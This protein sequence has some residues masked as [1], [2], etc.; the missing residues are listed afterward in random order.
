MP[1]SRAEALARLA[2]F[3]VR[4]KSLMLLT[5]GLGPQPFHGRT[6]ILINEWTSSA[7]EMAAAFGGGRVAATLLG[8]PTKGNVL[9]AINFQLDK[10]YWLRLPIFGWFTYADECL[11]DRGVIPTAFVPSESP[12]DV[13][14]DVQ[15]EVAITTV[16]DW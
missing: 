12:S 16:D 6:V 9:G 15:T 10:Q 4:D 7:G 3:A 2:A 8:Q 14:R 1:Q 13:R 5:Q 11:E